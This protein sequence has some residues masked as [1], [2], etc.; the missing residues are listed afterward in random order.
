MRNPIQKLF[1]GSIVSAAL[2][3]LSY[4][5]WLYAHSQIDGLLAL[6]LS[7]WMSLLAILW[8]AFLLNDGM[9]VRP[10]SIR[11]TRRAVTPLCERHSEWKL[12]KQNAE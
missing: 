1:L 10:H 8:F 3:V 2:F 6:L 11:N 4:T 7:V 9:E 5:L 12:S